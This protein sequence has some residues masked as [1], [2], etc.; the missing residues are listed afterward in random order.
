MRI[1]LIGLYYANNLGDAV[2]CDCC[3]NMLQAHYPQAQ[4]D[5]RD[6]MARTEFPAP[7]AHWKRDYQRTI[8]AIL[9]KFATEHNLVDKQYTHELWMLDQNRTYI[10]RVCS[11]N[12]DAVVFAGGQVFMD[13]LVMFAVEYVKRFAAKGTPIFFNACGTG[14]SFSPRIHEEMAQMLRNPAVKFI[15]TRDD[16]EAINRDYC[17][18]ENRVVNS[19]DPA[20]RCSEAYGI[21]KHAEADTVGLG[22]MRASTV[23]EGKTRRFWK[24]LILELNRRNIKWLAFTNGAD[25]DIAFAREILAKIPDGERHLAP[26]PRKPEDL[27][28]TIA[29]I[30]SIISFRLHSHIIAASLDI[31]SVALV[32]DH[33]LHD[34]FGRLGHPERCMTVD[35]SPEAVLN[36]L[37]RAEKEGYDRQELERQKAVSSSLLL[38]AMDKELGL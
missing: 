1:L 7:A 20:L 6:F 18:S 33:K 3:R 21:T 35:A 9:R 11:E 32:W 27:V 16:A 4:I 24:K 29:G 19:F 38:S 5:V 13:Y 25:E 30:R 15:S 10:D 26:I 22:I 8:R 23:S 31:P 37:H 14:P 34:F 12:Y 2:L 28:A 17:E 36:A